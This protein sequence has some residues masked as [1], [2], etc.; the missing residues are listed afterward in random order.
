VIPANQLA[1]MIATRGNDPARAVFE[2]VLLR[3]SIDRITDHL[4]AIEIRALAHRGDPAHD[5]V[6]QTCAHTTHLLRHELDDI[7]ALLADV[8]NLDHPPAEPCL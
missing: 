4:N 8:D 2:A 1:H 3:Q 6:W 5:G 7:D